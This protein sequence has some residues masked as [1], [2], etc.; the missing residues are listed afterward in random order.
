MTTDIDK[1]IEAAVRQMNTAQSIQADRHSEIIRSYI[2][3]LIKKSEERGDY[4][5]EECMSMQSEIATIK[6][7]VREHMG[8]N[9]MMISGGGYAMCR[10][11]LAR[12]DNT[13]MKRNPCNEHLHPHDICR[14]PHC[15]ASKL[16]EAVNE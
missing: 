12:H 9:D 6:T 15:P 1:A 7:L 16:R 14:N 2:A 10:Y 13:N 4:L 5:V 8:D 3:P 11:C